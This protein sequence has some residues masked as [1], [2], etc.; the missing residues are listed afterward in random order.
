MTHHTNMKTQIHIIKKEG[1]RKKSTVV[2][3]GFHLLKSTFFDIA[4]QSSC[5]INSHHL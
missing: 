1:M 4:D 5:Q 3:Q 2:S